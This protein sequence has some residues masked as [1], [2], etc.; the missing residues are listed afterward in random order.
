M[1]DSQWYEPSPPPPL[2]LLPSLLLLVSLSPSHTLCPQASLPIQAMVLDRIIS[3]P[4]ELWLLSKGDLRKLARVRDLFREAS[5]LM[6]PINPRELQK[7]PEEAGERL[8]KHLRMFKAKLSG[9]KPGDLLALPG[10]SAYH[11]QSAIQQSSTP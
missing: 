9:M 2:L 10:T 1:E 5:A 6:E 4:S 3:D 8:V 11:P 7:K